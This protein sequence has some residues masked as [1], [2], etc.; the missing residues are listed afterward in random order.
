MFFWK[1]RLSPARLDKECGLSVFWTLRIFLTQD[2]QPLGEAVP[3][4][5]G[6]W[7]CPGDAEEP[8]PPGLA[9]NGA[10][11]HGHIP[12]SQP[13]PEDI[14]MPEL[15]LCVPR[16]HRDFL[17]NLI[18]TSSGLALGRERLP[19]KEAHVSLCFFSIQP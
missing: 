11:P 7:W 10:V 6:G 1:S 9:P 8:S 14:A 13:K 4:T 12:L 5:R 3:H 15:G 17:S 16:S 18:P 19:S 2:P